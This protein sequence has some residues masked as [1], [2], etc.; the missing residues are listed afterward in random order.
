MPII[1]INIFERTLE[2]KRKLVEK[3]TDAVVEATGFKK[4]WVQIII[5]EIKQENIAQ[6]GK[7]AVDNKN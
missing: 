4:E 1:N 2:E 3:V 6:G 5:T 7:L